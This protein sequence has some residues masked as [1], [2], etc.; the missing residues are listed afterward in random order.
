MGFIEV[1]S[2]RVSHRD[3]A[4]YFYY[5][6]AGRELSL[7]VCHGVQLQGK[8]R[9]NMPS[10]FIPRN[11]ATIS[12]FISIAAASGIFYVFYSTYYSDDFPHTSTSPAL[13]RS[14]AVR[15]RRHDTQNH[16]QNTGIDGPPAHNPAHSNEGEQ[17]SVIVDDGA[18]EVSYTNEDN[19][20]QHFKELMFAIAK[21][22]AQNEGIIHR[23][24]RPS[25]M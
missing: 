1:L 2:L 6:C 8:S 13:R 22:R 19:E 10:S 4:V 21:H 25:G 23:G 16:E 17:S 12:A 14:N 7:F 5:Y 11:Q 24:M 18:T 15:R 9:V 3:S 20:G